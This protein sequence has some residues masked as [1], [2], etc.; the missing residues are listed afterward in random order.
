MQCRT[1]NVFKCTYPD[2]ISTVRICG[3]FI[4]SGHS[5]LYFAAECITL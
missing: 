5:P 4:Q 1:R 2:T 3:T